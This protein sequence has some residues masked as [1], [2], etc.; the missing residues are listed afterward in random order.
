MWGAQ[1]GW[2]LETWWRWCGG[3]EWSRAW[4]R[5][6]N[7]TRAQSSEGGVVQA[8]K[9]AIPVLAGKRRRELQRRVAVG[10]VGGSSLVQVRSSFSSKET[11]EETRPVVALR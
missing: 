5:G 8:R 7:K 2:I 1:G 3:V 4:S 9:R 10:D 11:T 6:A